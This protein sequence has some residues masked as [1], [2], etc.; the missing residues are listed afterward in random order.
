MA[1]KS[2]RPEWTPNPACEAAYDRILATA[3][4]CAATLCGEKPTNDPSANASPQAL[5]FAMGM[6]FFLARIDPAA[7]ANPSRTLTAMP[8][9][10][11]ILASHTKPGGAVLMCCVAVKRRQP[12]AVGRRR[13]VP[14]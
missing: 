8:G 11:R 4:L 7:S 6:M 1:R 5:M 13:K 14:S 3:H 12:S 9:S 2:K 10:I